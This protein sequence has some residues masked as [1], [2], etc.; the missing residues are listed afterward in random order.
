M[1]AFAGAYSSFY[2]QLVMLALI[3]EVIPFILLVWCTLLHAL[4][5]Y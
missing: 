3:S 4:Y 2:K 1:R 5:N